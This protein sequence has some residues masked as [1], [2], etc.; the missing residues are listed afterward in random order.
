MAAKIGKLAAVSVTRLPAGYHHDGGGLVLQVTKSGSRSWLFRY[1]YAG[2]RREMGLGPT[3]TVSLSEARDAA[4]QARKMLLNSI[5]PLEERKATRRAAEQR[6]ST[7]LT[8]G[9]CAEQYITTHQ[10]AWKNPKHAAQ[11]RST[12]ATYCAKFNAKPVFEV[13]RADVVTCLEKIWATKHETATRLRGRIE[14]VLDWATVHGYRDGEN[15]ARW[16]GNLDHLLPTISKTRRVQHHRA[17]P[18]QDVRDFMGRLHK[19]VGTAPKALEFLIL[20]ACR[21]GEIRA[22]TWDEIDES[23]Q[24]WTIPAARMKM[25][26]EHR[27]PLSRT[28]LRLLEALPRIEGESLVFP[29]T[30]RGKMLSDMALTEVLRRMNVDA[31][32]H[33]FRSTFRD[34]AG[35]ASSYPREVCEHALA[36]RLADGVEAAYQ[37]GDMLRKRREMME[38]WGMF[39]AGSASLSDELAVFL[40]GT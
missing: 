11:W 19:E 18:W 38:D 29:S 40:N 8:F 37:R 1:D 13:L 9:E 25:G 2:K 17:V 3:H 22:A 30:K 31:V 21:S 26:K 32:P 24:L 12:L 14:S 15:P 16:K 4:R 35:E 39:V 34:W 6:D 23:E 20:T 10:A 5:D 27:V 33:G 28:A 7:R 36:H